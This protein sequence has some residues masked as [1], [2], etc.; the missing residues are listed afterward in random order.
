MRA[1]D[2]IGAN[3]AEGEGRGGGADSTRFL[4]IARASAREARYWVQRATARNLLPEAMAAEFIAELTSIT[5]MLY[6]LVSH[7]RHNP[8]VIREVVSSYGEGRGVEIP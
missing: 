3:L 8:T 2:S 6:A 5:K 4:V 1:I 7:R